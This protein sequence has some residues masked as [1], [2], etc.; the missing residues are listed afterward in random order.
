MSRLVIRKKPAAF[1][2]LENTIGLQNVSIVSL[3]T[4]NKENKRIRYISGY[5]YVRS[6]DAAIFC[7]MREKLTLKLKSLFCIKAL[8]KFWVSFWKALESSFFFVSLVYL[9]YPNI[10]YS[11]LMLFR[12]SMFYCVFCFPF[13]LHFWSHTVK[14]F[15]KVFAQKENKKFFFWSLFMIK[16]FQKILHLN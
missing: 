6:A 16:K 1:G 13:S 11:L 5:F 3:I 9:R 4:K 7:N 12:T 14:L 8:A 10:S 2:H 15:R